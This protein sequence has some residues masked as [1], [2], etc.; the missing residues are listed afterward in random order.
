MALSRFWGISVRRRGIIVRTTGEVILEMNTA[1]RQFTPHV[2]RKGGFGLFP[3]AGHLEPD[4]FLFSRE[5]DQEQFV[6][7]FCRVCVHCRLIPPISACLAF[8]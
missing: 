2:Q 6:G 8:T 3:L 7:G 1:R 4:V 5:I